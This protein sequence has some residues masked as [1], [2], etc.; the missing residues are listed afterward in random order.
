M[1]QSPLPTTDSL[2]ALQEANEALEAKVRE[3]TR[4]L[5]DALNR[6][7][8]TERSFERLVSS[9]TDYALFML[10]TDGRIAS[11]NAGAE[12]IKGYKA[13]EIIGE[14]FSRFYTEEDRAAGVP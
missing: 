4:E 3:R 12:R 14:H 10:D 13:D 5:S 2:T 11:W 1:T 6:L 8:S 9:V 7:E